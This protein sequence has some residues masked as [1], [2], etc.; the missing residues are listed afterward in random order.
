MNVNDNF[1]HVSEEELLTP[2]SGMRILVNHYWWKNE[3][4]Y[5]FWRSHNGRPVP[6]TNAQREVMEHL[7]NKKPYKD[8]E[9]VL[10]PLSFVRFES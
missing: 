2:K 7:S 3:D 8:H 4:G 5:L 1:Y 10:L 9:I 6:Q